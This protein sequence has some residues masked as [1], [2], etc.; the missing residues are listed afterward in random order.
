MAYTAPP[1]PAVDLAA[2]V[3]LMSISPQNIDR[4]KDEGAGAVKAARFPSNHKHPAG[5]CPVLGNCVLSSPSPIQ[6]RNCC[7]DSWTTENRRGLAK[8]LAERLHTSGEKLSGCLRARDT[9]EA[10]SAGHTPR[11]GKKGVQS[12]PWGSFSSPEVSIK[13]GAASSDGG[14]KLASEVVHRSI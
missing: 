1:S 11:A 12:F 10:S 14:L 5:M 6:S 9:I 4:Y 8:K 2:Y 3:I 7:E 13:M